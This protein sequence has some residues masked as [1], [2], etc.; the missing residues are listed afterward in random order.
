MVIVEVYAPLARATAAPVQASPM[1]SHLGLEAVAEHVI[2][3]ICGGS[4]Q[5]SWWWVWIACYLLVDGALC[6]RNIAFCQNNVA[7]CLANRHSLV[8]PF[9]D[10]S[11]WVAGRLH[12]SSSGSITSHHF[13]SHVFCTTNWSYRSRTKPWI[14]NFILHNP[15]F[16]I[17]GLKH[18]I[19]MVSVSA[20]EL[21]W[22]ELH[23][24]TFKL[25][26]RISF[27]LDLPYVARILS[28]VSRS[29]H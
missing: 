29:L 5:L 6:L 27:L 18:S 10:A 23:H 14:H 26:T 4:S 11:V 1:Q 22:R 16:D 2:S 8:H 25:R 19:W 20:G 28:W 9:L 12:I 3:G 17:V 7:L 13:P 24:A 21:N 15:S